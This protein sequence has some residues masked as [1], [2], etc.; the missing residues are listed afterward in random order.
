MINRYV[1]KLNFLLTS[2]DKRMLVI[3]LIMS[4]VLSFVEVVGISAIMPFIS[5][6]SNPEL[7][8]SNEYINIFYDLL[9]FSDTKSFIIY[10]GISL[11]CFYIF[12]AIYIVY[13]S[14]MMSKF[15]MD[16]YTQV[17]NK[18]YHNYLNMPYKEYVT[19]NSGTISKV[20]VVE[21]LQLAYLL[22]NVLIFL[23]EVLIV[24]ILYSLLLFVD[25]KMT[26]LLTI[27]MAIK[28]VLLTKTVSKKIKSIGIQ[29]AVLQ[30]RFNIIVNE[31][32]G[33][34]KIIKF[35]SNQLSLEKKFSN[36]S[37]SFAKI[38][39]WNVTLSNI[40]RNFLESVGLS[41]L[42]GIV[43]YIVAFQDSPEKVIPIISM[44]A[45]ALYRLL[46][47][48]ARILN[49]YN[50]IVFHL[51]SLNIVYNDLKLDYTRE[52]SKNIDFK[53]S[54][55]LVN[56]SYSYENKQNIINNLTLE[57]N[58]G[59]KIAFIGESGSGKST[60]VD[61][62]CGIYKPTSGEIYIDN[63]KLLNDNVVSWRKKIGYIPQSIY[64]FDGTIADNVSFGRE[65][66]EKKVIEVLKQANIYDTIMLKD[67]LNTIVGEGGIQLSGG[68]K[69]RIG[70]ARALYGDPEV[71]VLDEATSALDTETE[72]A[73]M[74]EIYKVSEDK[75]L[76]V[77]AHRLSTIEKCNVKIDLGNMTNG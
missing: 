24:I 55:K 14:Y 60:L 32:L 44:Y 74:D 70:I 28:V 72:T 57:I 50:S 17:A 41:I 42:M 36:V 8:Y 40:P 23:S 29:R 35:L 53:N 64:L 76:L 5:V 47:A 68:Q 56:I 12:R 38:Q 16:K 59:Q 65:Y 20:I 31:S 6:A 10:F 34:F 18:L 4:V 27:L 25:I 39:I 71:L 66:D 49:S 48:T 9:K 15:A 46:P 1:N 77:I 33:N 75:T 51:P 73:I 3:L 58:K 67:G 30:E 63:Q 43:I 61:I 2:K 54:I 45:L 21:A 7:I 13:H 19:R 62:I 37:A 11:I 69:Q 52:Y 26:V 22:Q